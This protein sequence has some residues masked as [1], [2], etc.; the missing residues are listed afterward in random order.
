[1][2]SEDGNNFSAFH[3][4]VNLLDMAAHDSKRNGKCVHMSKPLTMFV[5]VFGQH[6]ITTGPN[7]LKNVRLTNI[8]VITYIF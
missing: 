8:S 5:R 6:G 4:S 2:L 1:M 3:F 7:I